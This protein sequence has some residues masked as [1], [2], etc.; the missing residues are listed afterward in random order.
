MSFLFLVIFFYGLCG[1]ASMN[2]TVFDKQLDPFQFEKKRGSCKNIFTM[3]RYGA[4]VLQATPEG[5]RSSDT[6]FHWAD[7]RPP[8]TLKLVD[9]ILDGWLESGFY[10]TDNIKMLRA[11]DQ[12]LPAI[13]TKYVSIEHQGQVSGIRIFD[14]SELPTN[15]G[16][17]WFHIPG[18]K[19][20]LTPIE[21]IY[22]IQLP[23]RLMRPPAFIWEL[24][25]HGAPK[26]FIKGADSTF[27]NVAFL[28]DA[29]YNN[30]NF[31]VMGT[32]DT[33]KENNMQIYAIVRESLLGKFREY[34]LEPV[35]LASS[36][37][38]VQP[39]RFPDGMVLVKMSGADF[40]KE[41][42]YKP[43]HP[44]TRDGYAK[45][46]VEKIKS[47]MA[48]L[49]KINREVDKQRPE[50][51]FQQPEHFMRTWQSLLSTYGRE[52]EAAPVGS[53]LREQNYFQLV[54]LLHIMLKD[55][56]VDSF[57]SNAP[58]K[59][60]LIK[61]LLVEGPEYGW[62]VLRHSFFGGRGSSTSPFDYGPSHF[63]FEN[64]QV[65]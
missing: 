19:E 62:A 13:R 49:Q 15:Q 17:P 52:I 22:N 61:E 55:P 64:P 58:V 1:Q 65:D 48:A 37:G 24:G 54:R 10:T 20:A 45:E 26:H 43:S 21:R 25:L 11:R 18:G 41:H 33:I 42:F 57:D 8:E 47:I 59:R 29:H 40:I 53:V 3:A 60:A 16:M 7:H 50:T 5:L 56:L 63:S 44:D 12:S 51:P 6:S 9:R 4:R 34:G 32:L 27:S 23:E 28:L 30:M 46:D 31:R 14:G 38:V 36:N 2:I 35:W 39:Y